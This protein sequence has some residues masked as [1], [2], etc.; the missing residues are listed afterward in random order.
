MFFSLLSNGGLKKSSLLHKNETVLI[1]LQIFAG[2]CLNCAVFGALMRPLE[3][4]TK[5]FVDEDMGCQSDDGE[6]DDDF[7]DDMSSAVHMTAEPRSDS[8]HYAHRPLLS[9][10]PSELVRTQ[11]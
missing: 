4:T 7:D 1:T 6:N 2:F 8:F 11:N 3:L 10:V 9:P 5:P